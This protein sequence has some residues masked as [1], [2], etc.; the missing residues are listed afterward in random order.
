MTSKRALGNS[1][2]AKGCEAFHTTP[3]EVD[4]HLADCTS[5]YG[6]EKTMNDDDR[7]FADD[8]QRGTSEIAAF[9]FREALCSARGNRCFYSL[10]RLEFEQGKLP[11]LGRVSTPQAAGGSVRKSPAS[12]RAWPPIS[13][14]SGFALA[15]LTQSPPG[16]IRISANRAGNPPR[17]A[18]GMRR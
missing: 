18:R 1:G 4:S 11:R 16:R 6:A 5:A 15:A 12:D 13:M 14:M 9:R 7:Q 8:L 10:S 17:A 2:N 3:R